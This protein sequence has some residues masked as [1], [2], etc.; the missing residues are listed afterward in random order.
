MYHQA[1]VAQAGN[2]VGN[3]LKKKKLK[4]I[5]VEKLEVLQGFLGQ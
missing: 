1:P 2:I 4:N 3:I 5:F